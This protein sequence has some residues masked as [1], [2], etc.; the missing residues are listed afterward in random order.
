MFAQQVQREHA[1]KLVR[2]EAVTEWIV[3]NHL[4]TAFCILAAA[5]YTI[6]LRQSEL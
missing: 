3:A 2:V 1:G 4:R 6:A 5:S